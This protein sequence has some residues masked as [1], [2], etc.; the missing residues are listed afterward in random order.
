MQFS[1]YSYY[2]YSCL[3]CYYTVQIIL[4]FNHVN[5]VS[6]YYPLDLECLA[7]SCLTRITFIKKTLQSRPSLIESRHISIHARLLVC[8]WGCDL[9]NYVHI[10]A[11]HHVYL[12]AL[13]IDKMA[14][15]G[16]SLLIAINNKYFFAYDYKQ[17]IVCSSEVAMLL[18][19]SYIE[20]VTT[21]PITHT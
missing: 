8:G 9:Q 20:E 16:Q 17:K 6:S 11:H 3:Y 2:V 18:V 4:Q 13:H 7:T 10:K 15:Q 5:E 19:M 1:M 12:F 14:F 21:C